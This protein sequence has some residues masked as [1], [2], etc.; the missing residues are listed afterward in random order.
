[1][2]MDEAFVEKLRAI[3]EGPQCSHGTQLAGLAADW[4]AGRR[5]HTS[6]DGA[7]S[8]LELLTAI[9]KSAMTGAPVRRGSI[10]AGDPFFES[11]HGGREI[12][13][14]LVASSKASSK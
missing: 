4:R 7:E 6:G 3:P 10:R 5:P 9:Y 1:P 13:H 8:T 12:P 14:R 11:F 2:E